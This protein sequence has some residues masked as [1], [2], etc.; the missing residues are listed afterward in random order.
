MRF[1]KIGKTRSPRYHDAPRLIAPENLRAQ[2]T[3]SA[4]EGMP[5]PARQPS[6]PLECFMKLASLLYASLLC[7]ALAMP[8]AAQ[9]RDEPALPYAPSLNL[10]SIDTSFDPC[11]NFYQYSCGRWQQ[12][13]LIP[14]DQTSWSV[15]GKLY[16][17]NLN[18]L[19]TILE[20]AGAS[21]DKSDSVTQTIGAFY[22]ACMDEAAIEKRGLQAIQPQLDAVFRLKSARDLA[23]LLAHLQLFTGGFTSILFSA[24]AAQD[25]DNSEQEIAQVDQAAWDFP[26]ATTT[27]KDDAKSK[28]IRERYVL[29]VQRIFQLLGDNAVTSKKNAA[30][31]MRM[32]TVLA[33]ASLTRVDRRDPYKLKNRLDV[34]ALGKLAPNFDWQAYYRELQY[35]KFEVLNV[36]APAF[37]KEL[38]TQLASEPLDNW[39]TYLRFHN[40]DSQAAYLSSSFA[41]ENFDFYRKY[42]RGAKQMQPRWKRCVQYTDRHLGEAL[43]QAYVRKVFLPNSSKARWRW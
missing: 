23:P 37:F 35:P 24:G 7:L 8:M 43:G 4:V 40:A 27:A 2:L 28:E 34:A 12:K 41:Q 39:K 36:T 30:T 5:R 33:Q 42:L 1:F 18:F 21:N 38:N 13:N 10:N 29:H 32:E 31:L 17:D 26:I 6:S 15:N 9:T 25:L 16:E 3:L 14:P 22:A 11:V 19:R 20:Q